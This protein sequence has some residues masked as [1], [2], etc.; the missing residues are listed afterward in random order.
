M[1]LYYPLPEE[2]D[3][4]QAR[5]ALN[6]SRLAHLWCSIY[7]EQHV[8]EQIAIYGG[9]KLDSSYARKLDYTHHETFQN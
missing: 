8:D 1:G 3:E 4:L 9:A 6:S 2:L 5:R 7:E